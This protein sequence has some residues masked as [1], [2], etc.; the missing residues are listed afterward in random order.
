M[1]FLS[2]NYI[3]VKEN[4][5]NMLL[6]VFE[7]F[8]YLFSWFSCNNQLVIILSESS[9]LILRYDKFKGLLFSE[10][11]LGYPISIATTDI[12]LLSIFYIIELM[13]IWKTALVV[14]N[15]AISSY[16]T[17]SLSFHL[18]FRRFLLTSNSRV[19][20]LSKLSFWWGISVMLVFI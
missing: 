5:L 7:I 13:K 6:F 18:A 8:K 1:L 16:H 2:F 9:N 10:M 14:D 12:L 15:Y 4:I 20:N 17:C 3:W 19:H 11:D